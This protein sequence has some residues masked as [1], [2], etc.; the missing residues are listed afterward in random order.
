MPTAQQIFTQAWV[1]LGVGSPGETPSA[2]ESSNGLNK[3]NQLLDSY[4]GARDMIYE[5]L[6]TAFALT[7]NLQSY[8]MGPTAAAPFNVQRPVKIETVN[9]VLTGVGGTGIRIPVT[10]M[11]TEEE[12]AAIPDRGATGTTPIGIYIDPKVPNLTLNFYP[13]PLVV[14]PTSVELGTWTAVQQFATLATNIN[15]PPAYYRML[16]LAE[17]I[18]IAPT[19]GQVNPTIIAERA[20]QLK[21]AVAIV[22]AIN[23]AVQNTPLGQVTTSA[24]S[25]GGNS[26]IAQLLQSLKGQ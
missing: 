1:D 25:G 14:T 16:V 19:Y 24:Q 21:E 3:L 11:F 26:Q 7:P 12:W 22:R 23:S 4:S 8:D 20:T 6:L 13:V 2:S 15:L 18:E 10:K 9:I 17:Q 5:I